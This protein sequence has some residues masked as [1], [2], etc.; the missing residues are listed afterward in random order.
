MVFK[1]GLTGGIASGKSTVTSLFYDK[2][3]IDIIDADRIAH[4][5]LSQGSPCYTK[6]VNIFG[7]LALLKNGDIN[8]RYLRERIFHEPN[9][10]Q[11]LEAIL[12]PVIHQQLLSKAESASSPYC[13]LSVP[14]LIEVG[15]HKEVDRVCVIDVSEHTQLERLTSRDKVSTETALAMINSQCDRQVRLQYADD[16]INNNHSV[17]SLA[18]Q[19]AQLHELYLNFA[20]K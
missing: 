16:I 11:Q 10:K 20:D 7:E 17:D 4:A 19:V 1:V 2:Y 13:I 12:H 6:V 15:M 8:R 18:H 14:L 5:L 3:Q 9:A